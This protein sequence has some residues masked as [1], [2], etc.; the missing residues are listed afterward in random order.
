VPIVLLLVLALVLVA[1]AA[2][3]QPA[4]PDLVV[5]SLTG[6]TGSV[7]TGAT[8]S[9]GA[10]VRNRGGARAVASKLGFFLSRDAKRSRDDLA[11]GGP[12]AIR[13]LRS[14]RKSTQGTPATI[15]EGTSAGEY[16][17]LACADAKGRV[18]E[19][20]EGNNCRAAS[21]LLARP[22]PLDNDVAPY[23]NDALPAG[24]PP[25]AG[26]LLLTEYFANPDSSSLAGDANGD[27]IAD[28]SDDEF[29]ELVNVSAHTLDLEGVV[30]SDATEARHTFPAAILDPGCAAVVFGGGSPSGVAGEIVETASSG[31]LDLS[32]GGDTVT[33][34]S[35]SLVIT[36]EVFSAEGE[37]ESLTL[38]GTSPSFYFKHSA[39]PGS[40]GPF[41]PG[42]RPDGTA[43][44]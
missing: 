18:G 34:A 30:V 7:T 29:V 15:P 42:L 40:V 41:S 27:G 33:V 4:K 37:N 32:D 16:S 19:K 11:L 10:T 31:K 28:E 17:L 3:E 36:D 8:I 1:P 39:L 25:E 12:V 23:G 38:P 20:Q 5:T 6:P 26:D 44:C 24:R 21:L 35:G 13:A 2:A 14:G 43:Y 9:L 22:L